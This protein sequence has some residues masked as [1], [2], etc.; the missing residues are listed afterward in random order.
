M[1]GALIYNVLW[2]GQRLLRAVG[3]WRWE[4][5]GL[6]HLP[7][8]EQGGMVVASNHLHWFDILILGGSLP[9]RYRLS[10]IAKSEIFKNAAATWFFRQ[11]L[12]IPIRRG[13][14][15]MAALEAAEAELRDGAV[16]TVF[17]EGHRNPR[18]ELQQG[19]GG[20]VRM[21]ARAG[22]PILPVAI[23]GTQ[24]GPLGAF[25]RR[26]IRVTIG[27]PYHPDTDGTHIPPKR[28]DELTEDMML[29]L[30]ALLPDQYR[31]YYRERLLEAQES[32]VRSQESGG[33]RRE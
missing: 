30:A 20:A 22:V 19:R 24:G 14:R 4:I 23:E 27:Q 8:R 2:I 13:A 9:M 31:G 17:V 7:P 32:G 26:Q 29:R 33:E 12:V 21:A 6:E 11:M 3:W 10:W 25:A 16:L 18:G 5:H 15:D 28:M 1:I